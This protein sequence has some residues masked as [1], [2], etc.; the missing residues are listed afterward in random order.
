MNSNNF[1]D[2]IENNEN[3]VFGDKNYI[4][5]IKQ[6]KEIL[7]FAGV[8][9][10][11]IL[12]IIIIVRLLSVQVISSN[13][14]R[15]TLIG[16]SI[17]LDDR[18]IEISDSNL[19]EVT[20]INRVTE[21]YKIDVVNVQF[22]INLEDNLAVETATLKF[23][24]D[25]DKWVYSSMDIENTKNIEVSSTA[26][27]FVKELLQKEGLST[28]TGEKFYGSY[29]KD[30]SGIKFE[31]YGRDNGKVFKA[32]LILSNG[33][34]YESFNIRGQILFDES[35]GMWKIKSVDMNVKDNLHKEEKIDED[36]IR[37][38]LIDEITD[39]STYELKKESGSEYINIFKDD[40]TEFNIGDYIVRKDNTIRVEVEGKVK[41]DKIMDMSFNGFISINGKLSCGVIRNSKDIKIYGTSKEISKSEEEVKEN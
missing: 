41:S 12:G 19:N 4:N 24:Y 20:I 25:S 21:K 40:I 6:N 30:V 17:E 10:V 7:G 38:I 13:E 8:I 3:I 1:N 9:I 18:K 26:E 5:I 31:E 22:K 23:N 39:G 29:V 15:Q 34:C 33:A 14:I 2:K 11:M 32:N 27:S 37:R 36:I 28:V 35:R 16:K